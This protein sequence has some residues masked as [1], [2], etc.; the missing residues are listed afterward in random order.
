MAAAALL[1]TTPGERVLDLAAAPGGKATQLAA[2]MARLRAHRAGFRLYAA[3]WMKR[4][5]GRQR[6]SCRPSAFA[7]RQ[8]GPLG[9][10]N[11]LVTQ[12]EPQHLGR[13]SAPV[14]DR[15]LI[16]APFA[17][18]G[19]DSP[20]RESGMGRPYRGPCAPWRQRH[21]GRRARSAAPVAVALFHLP[22]PRRRTSKSWPDFLAE[23]PDFQLMDALRSDEFGQGRP[24][25]P[26]PADIA[27]LSR[28][29]VSG[30][31]ALP[32]GDGSWH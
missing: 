23:R 4:P 27:Q 15:V 1:S 32:A 10:V 17:P 2:L 22:L 18:G 6:R 19:D 31:I 5:A 11:V 28:A 24:G 30:L 20:P 9:A 8:S 26:S 25:G 21:P 7:G 13:P 14:F 12:D 29:F 16:D 3:R